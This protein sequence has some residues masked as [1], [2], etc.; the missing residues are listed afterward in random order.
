M[1]G[2][3]NAQVVECCTPWQRRW[4]IMQVPGVRRP[5]SPLARRGALWER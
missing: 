5:G 3:C 4:T 1:S 2:Y